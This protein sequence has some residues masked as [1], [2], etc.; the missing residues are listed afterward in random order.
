MRS[1]T[2]RHCTKPW[3]N[4]CRFRLALSQPDLIQGATTRL[5]QP[6]LAAGA[7][8]REKTG[9]VRSDI[10]LSICTVHD[11]DTFS[12]R[13][14]RECGLDF[15]FVFRLFFLRGKAGKVSP[16]SFLCVIVLQLRIGVPLCL[17][18]FTER[19]ALDLALHPRKLSRWR[20][21]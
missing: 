8:K 6:S 12:W 18:L 13:S 2:A 17:I 11:G 1:C 15:F 7:N 10:A 9:S 21:L 14:E 4:Y 19:T 16:C 5:Y 20:I 3:P